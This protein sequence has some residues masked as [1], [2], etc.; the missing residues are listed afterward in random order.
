MVLDLVF[1]VISNNPL[2]PVAGIVYP[3]VPYT[4]GDPLNYV[5]WSTLEGSTTGLIVDINEDGPNGEHIY[6]VTMTPAIMGLSDFPAAF[7]IVT[8][9]NAGI[10]DLEISLD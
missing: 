8:S 10:N 1:T 3:N 5:Q 6:T 2:K 4:P 7:G 9:N